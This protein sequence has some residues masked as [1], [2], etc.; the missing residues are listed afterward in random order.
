SRSFWLRC[1]SRKLIC[2]STNCRRSNSRTSR[3]RSAQGSARP[4]AGFTVG[5]ISTKLPL[6][7]PPLP[8][9]DHLHRRSAR[10]GYRK[11]GTTFDHFGLMNMTKPGGWMTIYF[12][13]L[14]YLGR[15]QDFSRDPKWD[16][17]GNRTTYQ[18][19]DVRGAH[20][21]GFSATNYDGGKVGEVG[22]TFWHSG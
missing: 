11:Q 14:Q 22:G 21:F 5:N 6:I 9:R 10:E 2:C 1:R 18:S 12:D 7:P 15:T 20:D 16:A 8:R 13:D 4:S 3:S 19:K 17:S